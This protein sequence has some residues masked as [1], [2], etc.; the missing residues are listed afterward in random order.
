MSHSLIDNHFILAAL[1][2]CL[3][4]FTK[5]FQVSKDYSFNTFIL[6]IWIFCAVYVF[7][8]G[9]I[10]GLL[11]LSSVFQMKLNKKIARVLASVY[12][13][14]GRLLFFPI[15]VFLLALSNNYKDND[16][17]DAR[18]YRS[19]FKVISI[20]ICILNNAFALFIEFTMYQITQGKN[21][22]AAKSN[23]FHQVVIIHK[24][25]V[26]IFAFVT[27][28]RNVLEPLNSTFHLFFTCILVYIITKKLPF[29]DLRIL[30]TLIILNTVTFTLSCVS[31]LQ[32][33]ITNME[34]LD[35][36]CF[37]L[38]MFPIFGVKIAFSIY[39]A[40]FKK[41]LTSKHFTPEYAIQYVL[42]L[43]ELISGEQL[44][45][46]LDLSLYPN[47][48]TFISALEKV[49]INIAKL[50]NETS[51]HEREFYMYGFLVKKLE[52]TYIRFPNSKI[53]IVFMMKIYLEKLQNI[54]RVTELLKRL[55]C[56][57]QTIQ[58]QSAID[59]FTPKIEAIYK[60]QY[61]DGEGQIELINYF[62]FKNMINLIKTNMQKESDKHLEFW[63]D[64]QDHSVDV[65][66]TIHLAGEIDVVGT[67]L[68][69]LYQRD[70]EDFRQSFSLPILL[71]SVYLT[72]VHYLPHQGEKMLKK[73][74]LAALNQMLKAESG[75][76]LKETAVAVISLD[77]KKAGT[78]LDVS[79]SMESLF[80][81][82]KHEIIGKN[83]SLLFPNVI[84][85]AYQL[86]VLQYARSPSHKLDHKYKTY[87]KTKS[88]DIFEM[89]VHFQLYSHTNKEI[90]VATLF[91]KISNPKSLLIVNCDGIITS[92]SKRLQNNLLQE[93]VSIANFKLMQDIIPEFQ[94]IN[95]SYN[96]AFNNDEYLKDQKDS[97]N[98]VTFEG[99]SNFISLVERDDDFRLT[100]KSLFESNLE[101]VTGY[102]SRTEEDGFLASSPIGK[103]SSRR[104]LNFS[105]ISPRASSGRVQETP[106]NLMESQRKT[107]KPTKIEI[108]LDRA[109]M[110]CEKYLM[111]RRIELSFNDNPKTSKPIKIKADVQIKP[112]IL[113]GEIYKVITFAN[114]KE[115]GI[116]EVENTSND[117]GR[118][119]TQEAIPTIIE[120]ENH[121]MKAT[122]L[123]K[124]GSR[125]YATS[126]MKPI[127]IYTEGKSISDD[128]ISITH[129]HL[130]N[131]LKDFDEEE[132]EK[133][134]K[135]KE[136][137]DHL[138]GKTS[139]I[140]HTYN[141]MR[142]IKTLNEVFT[143]KKIQPVLKISMIL[144]YL[145]IIFI[146]SLAAINYFLSAQAL[147]EIK[148]G[149]H[150]VNYA[151]RRLLFIQKAWQWA[152][153]LYAS[154]LQLVPFPI[155]VVYG[156]QFFLMD[157]TWAL[158]NVNHRLKETL[159]YLE[160]GHI[161]E[162]AFQKNVKFY[163]PVGG[164]YFLIEN[165]DTFT[166][167]DVLVNRYLDIGGFTLVTELAG[168]ETIPL[169]FNNTANDYMYQ[170]NEIILK[171]EEFLS[172]I[173]G[174]NIKTMNTVLASETVALVL[175]TLCLGSLALIIGI[176]YKRLFKVLI[177][178]NRN[179]VSLRIVQIKNMMALFDQDF[180]DKNFINNTYN[181][182][183][184]ANPKK[185]V[186]TYTRVN[187]SK[188]QT[189]SMQKMNIYLFIIFGISLI[190]VPVLAGLF[191]ASLTGSISA[192]ESFEVANIQ[193]GILSQASFQSN[194]FLS[195]FAYTVLFSTY[196]SLL[197][198]N[199]SP[200]VSL[201]ENM[202]LFSAMNM[203]LTDAFLH[204]DNTDPWIEG[205][206]LEKV[207][208][209]LVEEAPEALP[210]C[211][212]ATKGETIG[213][214]GVN[215][216]YLTISVHYIG[217][218]QRNPTFANLQVVAGKFINDAVPIMW[219]INF[220]YPLMVNH[221]MHNF[222]VGADRAER[223]EFNYFIGIC[224]VVVFAIFFLYFVPY[225]MLKNVEFARRKILKIIPYNIIQENKILGYYIIRNFDQEVRGIKTLL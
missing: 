215:N 29:Y 16:T 137:E 44:K 190:F 72:C 84:A 189:F 8:H 14:H 158:I 27:S 70:I 197:I 33:V 102:N 135:E 83:F 149:L 218:F 160:A 5:V 166:A 46:S 187:A 161:L 20:L 23:S 76:N 88:G 170:N 154:G 109:K 9:L 123:T 30:K 28:S 57:K 176:T 31:F 34:I 164:P 157:N 111:G 38:L 225:K 221:T 177:K 124:W 43:K 117:F 202:S 40:L 103:G 68:Q 113:D 108:S 80:Q 55:K 163:T 65:K 54:S 186:K 12:L 66:K 73:Y 130:V 51:V 15:Q 18:H 90:A 206:L 132:E 4:F 152:L 188:Y 37:F 191:A 36:L 199:K 105:P 165:F 7:L 61:L 81:S 127:R 156:M 96:L 194:M 140:D 77:P 110:I 208:P 145:I 220:A 184:E 179:D 193:I 85:K 224:G 138:D 62:K 212:I 147:K 169:T 10:I 101:L 19:E 42:I 53:L 214:L 114:L 104:N 17:E 201:Q 155:D 180:E 159:S 121:K 64:L 87:G 182:F 58:V 91:K 198:M 112:Y 146:I 150:I 71:Y 86:R 203:K 211:Q 2:R 196:P 192:F 128:H 48:Y 223:K 3:G 63:K 92:F 97:A 172:E 153:F 183:N 56:F 116:D 115:K 35:S 69:K 181:T 106:S 78:I 98:L 22:Y 52:D 209:F 95:L 89:E 151:T 171:T 59:L 139:S 204:K 49:G 32:A 47:R 144:A 195:A 217:E 142:I 148:T 39:R 134:K 75:L 120:D 173:I 21:T 107:K 168:M 122:T 162:G 45:Y 67:F 133:E 131:S 222:E 129:N 207:C 219:T 60:K 82:K 74:E 125:T 205:M 185:G 118:N 210:N 24:T 99:P 13:I 119:T 6:P 93:D 126:K 216:D 178:I 175:L 26:I 1:Y 41:I 200:F 94:K 143:R 25:I 79:I 167:T 11:I 100:S 213:L 50:R 136:E 174:D 141:E